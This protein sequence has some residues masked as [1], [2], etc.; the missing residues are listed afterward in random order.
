MEEKKKTHMD[1]ENISESSSS[2]G[3]LPSNRAIIPLIITHIKEP[4]TRNFILSTE[5]S[6]QELDNKILQEV[7]NSSDIPW[8]KIFLS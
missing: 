6:C 4:K 5:S 1:E 2:K 7:W 8:V 3:W